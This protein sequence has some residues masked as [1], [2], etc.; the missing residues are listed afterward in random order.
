M[1][2]QATPTSQG[3]LRGT[4][5]TAL[6]AR[7]ATPPFDRLWAR[8]AARTRQVAQR[9]LRTNFSDSHGSLRWHSHTPMLTAAAL[10][11]LVEEDEAMLDYFEKALAFADAQSRSRLAT[12]EHLAIHSHAEV[13]IAADLLR[14]SLSAT[15][16]SR[17]C[18]FMREV[19]IDSNAGDAY[20]VQGGGGNISWAHNVQAGVCA[21]LWGQECGHPRWREVVQDA[22]NHTRAYLEYGCDAGGF[23]Y[24]G[25]GYGHSVFAV[26]F[27]F[28]E[29]LALTGFANLYESEPRLRKIGPAAQLQ[30]FPN[31]SYLVNDNDMGLRGVESMPYL[32]LLAKRFDDGSLRG[33][34]EAYQ[35]PG[36]PIRPYGDMQPW[37][38]QRVGDGT[39]NLDVFL[40]DPHQSLFFAFLSWEPEKP[41]QALQDSTLPLAEYSRGTE[42]VNLRTSW[43]ADAVY[44]N[45]LGSGRSPMSLT[46]GHTDAGHF[47]LFAH[48]EYLAID[49]GRYNSDEDQHSVMLV[50][51][52]PHQAIA[53]GWGI[54]FRSGRVSQFESQPLLSHTRVDAAHQKGC[55]WAVRDFLW[56]PLG[57]DEAYMVVLDNVNK[58]NQH[59]RF[60]WQL[61]A[62]P[63]AKIEIENSWQA[64]VVRQHARLE[65]SCAAPGLTHGKGLAE[66]YLRQ[67]VKEW[68]YPYGAEPL[69][70]KRHDHEGLLNTSYYRP[71]LLAEHGNGQVM[72]VI[73]PRR[74]AAPPLLVRRRDQKRLLWVEIETPL[75]TD[76]IIAAPN[77]GFIQT[78]SFRCLTELLFL[79][80]DAAG[81]RTMVW[82]LG[83]APLQPLE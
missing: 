41:V 81:E 38:A 58:D 6:R 42:I 1:N 60:W 51:G 47:S 37:I 22:I 21:L 49:T 70:R 72:T 64:R 53:P 10:V 27:P 78:Q 11:H 18:D 40:P 54:E 8:L 63:H 75:G 55:L 17:L 14:G 76:T 5:A 39:R 45:L 33:L 48:G 66:L 34:W 26:M 9:A 67:D 44:A 77:H 61:Q 29:L 57:N 46:H 83:G 59:H 69:L 43:N 68:H 28:L 36:H 19:A 32:L 13:A 74:T 35:G 62:H 7:A 30:M 82:S 71:R 31:G 24:E 15:A 50:N 3:F 25:S 80:H 73:A 79:R 4:D 23:S 65:I 2:G 52:K 20:I 56:V 16:R 12:N